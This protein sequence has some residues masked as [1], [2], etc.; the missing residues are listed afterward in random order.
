[1][2]KEKVDFAADDRD[3]CVNIHGSEPFGYQGIKVIEIGEALR[4]PGLTVHQ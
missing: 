1:V 3:S 4:R 2:K